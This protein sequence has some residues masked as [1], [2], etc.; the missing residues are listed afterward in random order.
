MNARGIIETRHRPIARGAFV[1]TPV[2][3][4]P[5]PIAG[6][7]ALAGCGSMSPKTIPT[8][9]VFAMRQFGYH[10]RNDNNATREFKGI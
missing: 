7:A 6:G 1:V 8:L 5:R 10:V 3:C 4:S 2:A 9:A